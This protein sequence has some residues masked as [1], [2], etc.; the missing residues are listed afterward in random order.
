M[1]GGLSLG[2]VGLSED[3]RRSPEYVRLSTASD[4][5]LGFSCGRFYR[6][7]KLYCINLLLFFEEGCGANCL[8][9]GQAREISSSSICKTLIRVEWPLR[10]LGEVIEAYERLMGDG[11]FLR[12]Y[13]FC[14]ASVTHPRAVEAERRV[15]ERLYERLNLPISALISPTIFKA[16]DVEELRAAGVERVGI[17]VDCATPELFDLLRGRSARGPHRFE[18]YMEG[19]EEAVDIM[20]RGKVGVHLIV[21]LGETER[22]AAALMQRIRD[23]GAE[24]HLF[25]FYPEEGSLLEEWPRV[26]LGQY[27]RVQM[28]RY[29]IDG[30]R[31]RFEDME[32]NEYGQIVDYGLSGEGVLGVASTGRP[33]MTSGC[34]GCNRPYANERPRETPRNYPY[35]PSKGEGLRAYKQSLRYRKPPRSTMKRLSRYLRKRGYG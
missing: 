25:A 23:V 1:G 20:G 27:R 21:G 8:Y 2:M 32:F 3:S 26:D 19:V 35:R 34:P 33:F 17:A 29:L 31:S 6:D 4:I 28:A 7:V 15:V 13:R 5:T 22:D 24:T 11:C 12:P 30:G 10:P 9:C 14:V 16:K 18:R